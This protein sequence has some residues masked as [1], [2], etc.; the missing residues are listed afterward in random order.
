MDNNLPSI[1]FSFSIK[2]KGEETGEEYAGDFLYKR[3]T[4]T[5]KAEAQRWYNRNVGEE[6]VDDNI[7]M[8]Y[9]ILSSVRFGVITAPKWFTESDNGANMY[10][11]NVVGS[12]FEKIQ[13]SSVS[14]AEE[15]KKRAAKVKI[16]KTQDVEEDTDDKKDE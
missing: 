9:T 4:I 7:K 15:V 10:D 1:E 5:E 11:F 3:L 16:K 6:A 12:I 2:E 8:V 14:W 13:E